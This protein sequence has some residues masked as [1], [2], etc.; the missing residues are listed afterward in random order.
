MMIESLFIDAAVVVEVVDG[1]VENNFEVRRDH[2][3]S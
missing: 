2:C 1:E 3:A